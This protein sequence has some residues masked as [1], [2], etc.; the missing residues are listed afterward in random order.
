MKIK[1]L[2]FVI[3]LILLNFDAL[4]A[5]LTQT[6]GPKGGDGINI[7]TLNDSTWIYFD[8]FKLQTSTDK[9]NTW[10]SSKNIFNLIGKEIPKVITKQVLKVIDQRIYFT[11]NDLGLFYSDDLGVSF[12]PI[13][14]NI[15]S[16]III[17]Q[18][19]CENEETIVIDSKRNI[20]YSKD[21]ENWDIINT[22]ESGY[23]GQNNIEDCC[24][25]WGNIYTVQKRNYGDYPCYQFTTDKGKTWINKVN[26]FFK[27]DFL[28]IGFND[29]T[30]IVVDQYGYVFYSHDK[31][32]NWVITDKALPKYCEKIVDIVSNDKYL[33]MAF[34]EQ[35]VYRSSDNGL[36]WEDLSKDLLLKVNI[37]N[38]KEDNNNLFLYSNMGIFFSTNNGDNWERIEI[39]HSYIFEMVYQNNTLYCPTYENGIQTTTDNGNTWSQLNE[40][41]KNNSYQTMVAD[42]DT[43]FA[44]K[45]GVE[46]LVSVDK[47]K[48]FNQLNH[49][50][51]QSGI[52]KLWKYGKYLFGTGGY[53]GTFR[54]TDYG[55]SWENILFEGKN[56]EFSFEFNYNNNE[57]FVVNM[58]HGILNSNDM[59]SNWS[60]V[61]NELANI[62]LNAIAIEDDFMCCA[63][64]KA[65]YYSDNRGESW[66]S[67]KLFRDSVGISDILIYK[68]KVFICTSSKSYNF[69][70]HIYV[71]SDHCNSWYRISDSTLPH[72]NYVS[73]LVGGDNLFVGTGNNGVWKIKLSD[74]DDLL[75][76]VDDVELEKTY[77]Y[78]FPP[79]PL[80][81]KDY[82]SS[83]IYW[84]PRYDFK[85]AEIN[86]Y[87]AEGMKVCGKERITVSPTSS[88]S[89]LVTL[90]TA[91]FS[92]GVYIILI[93]HHTTTLS[94]KVVIE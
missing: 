39:N 62:N 36:T 6:N 56:L 59:G 25:K 9:G 11:C 66:K 85:D 40:E 77:L 69:Q 70:N 45:N 42:G 20:Y 55:K 84:D 4:N 22:A 48:S 61:N 17:Q 50:V 21:N 86:V 2:L 91:G 15:F 81:G 87:N 53:D 30:L 90:N 31:G 92:S 71:S 75:V 89:S 7:P 18:I 16:G 38:F 26:G 33:F 47:G 35:G 41:L 60:I 5:Q 24:I 51:I 43:I 80:P 29:S 78:A 46:L 67:T 34:N 12:H 44:V 57:L 65:F 19:E 10:R 1:H 28:K 37:Y 63:N 32:F 93:K 82:I 14:K 3:I 49:E 79:F 27:A 52:A 72:T 76:P 23:V 54:S 83:E 64:V 13:G 94:V 8:G 58:K 88:W 74:I 68:G 73:L